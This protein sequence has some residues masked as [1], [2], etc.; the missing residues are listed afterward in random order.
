MNK[1]AVKI[2]LHAMVAP[3]HPYTTTGPPPNT[4]VELSIL[5]SNI[6][7]VFFAGKLTRNAHKAVRIVQCHCGITIAALTYK[8]F[9]GKIRSNPT[10][11]S[12]VPFHFSNVLMGLTISISPGCSTFEC[13]LQPPR[14]EQY[15]DVR[16][17]CQFPPECSIFNVLLDCNDLFVPN[18][19]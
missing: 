4:L 2:L 17:L 6:L 11:M 5:F 12:D 18:T 7:F 13:T 15:S 14:V 10:V 1:M 19:M 8:H 9:G 3:H 16:D